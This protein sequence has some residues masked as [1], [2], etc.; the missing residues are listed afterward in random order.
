MRPFVPALALVTLVALA[1]L[2]PVRV[3]AQHTDHAAHRAARSD[4]APAPVSATPR[5][6]TLPG[7]DAFA[8]I[9]EIVR[10]LKADPATDWSKVD[11]EALRQHLIDMH[12]VTLHSVV[13]S[14]PIPGG[15]QLTVTGTGRTS[16]AIRRMVGAHGHML[17][18]EGLEGEVEPITDGVRWRVTTR[19]PARV[20][21]VRGLGFIGILTLGEH[22]TSHHL[23]LARGENPH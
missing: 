15:V 23:A 12:E 17:A 7:Q 6:A 22:H 8:A 3:S 11:L 19:D 5:Q 9:G 4:S 13:Q 10:I 18:A 2:G 21:E 1:T 20:T 16:A 14:A